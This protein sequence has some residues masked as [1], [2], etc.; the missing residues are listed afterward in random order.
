MNEHRIKIITGATA[1]GKSQFALKMAL[2]DNA[3]IISMDSMQIYKQLNAG[4]AKPDQATLK[5]VKH[6]L[7][8]FIEPDQPYSVARYI[9]DVYQIINSDLSKN[10]L[11]VGGTG[12]YLSAL[13]GAELHSRIEEQGSEVLWQ[14]LKFVDPQAAS[15]ITKNDAYRITRALEVYQKTGKPISSLQK[16]DSSIIPQREVF[17]LDMPREK[18]YQKIEQRVDVMLE[19][20]LLDE[21]NSLLNSG[22]APELP[23]LQAIGYKEIIQHLRGEF[24]F[25]TAVELIKKNTRNFA[26][27]QYTWFRKF[28][29]I[30]WLNVDHN[31]NDLN[32]PVN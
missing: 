6:H 10:Y 28:P 16:K 22:Y 3:E 7:I 31:I 15:K 1:S 11:I 9:N 23:A 13:L 25:E 19:G 29:E 26:K 2:K 17:C 4:T 12:L 5:K 27:R 32:D 24:G 30:K 20:G 8:D 21:V 18:L 14:E